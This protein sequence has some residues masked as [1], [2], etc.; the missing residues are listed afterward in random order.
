MSQVYSPQGIIAGSGITI[1]GDLANGWIIIHSTGGGGGGITEITSVDDSVTI[2]DPTGPTV[3]LSVTGGSGTITEITS[4]DNTV[5]I[6]DP[7]GPTTD[8]SVAGG[9]T[10]LPFQTFTGSPI[11]VV[12]PTAARYIGISTDT[13]ALYYAVGAT[14]T[15]WVQIAGPYDSTAIGISIDPTDAGGIILQVKDASASE[16]IALIDDSAGISISES[17]PGSVSIS[18]SGGNVEINATGSGALNGIQIQNSNAND[19]IG[20]QI[21]DASLSGVS[22]QVS[23]ATGLLFIDQAGGGGIKIQDV[24]AGAPGSDIVTLPNLPIGDP[25]NPGQIY[26]GASNALFVSV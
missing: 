7:S 21:S 18:N 13:D 16:G 14:D 26:V 24:G 17:G 22:I 25:S 15:D 23:G 8:L 10:G 2:T 19:N 6:T 1:E 12:V 4:V 11:G 3:D 9:G 20:V 5:T